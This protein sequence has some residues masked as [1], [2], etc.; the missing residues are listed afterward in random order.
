[1]RDRVEP[2]FSLLVLRV[3]GLLLQLAV[4]PEGSPVTLKLVAPL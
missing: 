3:R 4:T 2:P 1:M